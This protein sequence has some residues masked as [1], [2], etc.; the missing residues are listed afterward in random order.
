MKTNKYLKNIHIYLLFIVCIIIRLIHLDIIEFKFDEYIAI[1]LAYNNLHDMALVG[2]DHLPGLYNPPF[3]I[4]LMTIP[5]IFSTNPIFVTL[6]VIL[7]NIAAIFILYFFSLKIFNKKTAS[8]YYSSFCFCSMGD[9]LLKENLGSG[10][11]FILYDDAIF[12]NCFIV[13]RIQTLQSD[14]Y[15]FTSFGY[16]STSYERM[17]SVLTNFDIFNSFQN[18]NQD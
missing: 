18:Q 9:N 10:L 4:Y 13:R 11:S 8:M 14:C 7:L 16:Y 2:F 15:I 6:F 5:V 3:F 12:Y 1:K 17:V